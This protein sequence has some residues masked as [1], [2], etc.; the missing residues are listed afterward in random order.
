M[1][2]ERRR[3]RAQK[4]SRSCQ[5]AGERSY[6]VRISQIVRLYRSVVGEVVLMSHWRH[7]R[8]RPQL[9]AAPRT[10]RRSS[11]MYYSPT[12]DWDRASCDTVVPIVADTKNQRVR[13][14]GHQRGRRGSV[15][16]TAGCGRSIAPDPPVPVASTPESVT[17][18]DRGSDALTERRGDSDVAL[19]GRREGAPDWPYRTGHWSAGPTATSE[20][21]VTLDTETVPETRSLAINARKSSLGAVVENA[22]EAMVVL[23]CRSSE[24]D[25][26]IDGNAA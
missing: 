9:S 17:T 22:G 14:G 20:A 7:S 26:R 5:S 8:T 25:D 6:G 19:G 16:R 24:G 15:V 10:Y 12:S 23:R 11:Q 1:S 21:P 4:R 3:A 18:S 13:A 2:Y